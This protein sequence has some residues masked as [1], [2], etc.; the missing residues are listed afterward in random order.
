MRARPESYVIEDRAR[1]YFVGAR[2][3][4]G[5]KRSRSSDE[6]GQ[7]A[8]RGVATVNDSKEFR[9][10]RL[11]KF[12]RPSRFA[13]MIDARDGV[14]AVARMSLRRVYIATARGAP[15][16]YPCLKNRAGADDAKPVAI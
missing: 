15:A 4:E 11:G 3:G 12:R 10:L 14:R 13:L 1:D 7:N 16:W 6:S 8:F 9:R 5:R 2:Y